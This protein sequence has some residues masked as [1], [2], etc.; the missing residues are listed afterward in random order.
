MGALM[1]DGLA[2]FMAAIRKME[3]GG[4]YSAVNRDS[5]AGGAYQFM[6]ATWRYAVTMAGLGAWSSTAPQRAPAWVQDAAAAALM[7]NYYNRW[8]SWY[9]VAEAW[10]GGPG[11]VGDPN[12]GGGP[13]YP[14]VGQYALRIT[15]IMAGL[16]PGGVYAPPPSS[17]IVGDAGRAD[18]DVVRSRW[19]YVQ[20]TLNQEMPQVT[21]SIRKAGII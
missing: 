5:G 13:G 3:S 1:A 7:T 20:R 12:R 2:C 6:P 11:A 16:C 18:M 14:T 21:D 15:Q 17:P 8:H 9:S 19:G 10:Y 4:N